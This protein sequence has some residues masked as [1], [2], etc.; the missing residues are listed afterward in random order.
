M[1]SGRRVLKVIVE[2]LRRMMVVEGRVRN[3]V[4]YLDGNGEDV[5]MEE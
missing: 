2:W 1:C 4:V 3:K 5:E